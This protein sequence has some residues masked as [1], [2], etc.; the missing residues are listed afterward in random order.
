MCVAG[1]ALARAR[2][3]AKRADRLAESYWELRYEIGQLKGRIHRLDISVGLAEASPDAEPATPRP[4]STT[5]FV[6][7]SSLKK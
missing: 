5:S 6:P 2:R 7:L 3:A 4:A 1:V